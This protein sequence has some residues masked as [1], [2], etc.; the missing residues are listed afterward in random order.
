MPRILEL[1]LASGGTVLFEVDQEHPGA[2]PYRGSGT[3][4]VIKVAG[5]TFDSVVARL[6]PVADALASQLGGLAH[7][8]DQVSVEFGVKV[9][10][11]A[12]VVIAKAGSEASLRI[13]LSWRKAG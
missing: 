12:G 1:P 2:K 9:T 11:D 7:A 3:E 6:R 8:P 13:T 5:E 10:A 4:A